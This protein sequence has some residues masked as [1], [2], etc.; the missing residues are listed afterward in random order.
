MIDFQLE[1]I[2]AKPIPL[3]FRGLKIANLLIN[4][5][6]I[7]DQNI[8]EKPI[9]KNQCIYLYPEYLEEGSNE[10]ELDFWSEYRKEGIGLHSFIDQVD[11]SQ[12]V[13]SM[14]CEAN[15]RLI[16][17]C[18]DQPDLKATFSLKTALPDNWTAV[19]NEMVHSKEDTDEMEETFEN[20][21]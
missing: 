2:P 4:D 12:Y 8:D 11:N 10:I 20:I 19:S 14:S 7:L 3:D 15:C 21:F 5:Q 17:P 6:T 18:F 9:F 13:W 1:S 16:F